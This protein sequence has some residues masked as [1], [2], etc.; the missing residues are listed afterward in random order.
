VLGNGNKTIFGFIESNFGFRTLLLVFVA[1]S[2]QK[3]KAFILELF[4]L[5]M[6]QD[7]TWRKNKSKKTSKYGI[8]KMKIKNR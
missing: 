4:L 2:R 3:K 5:I 8:K 6:I 7:N 1:A